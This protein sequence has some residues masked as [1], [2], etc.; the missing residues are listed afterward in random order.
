[1]QSLEIKDLHISIGDKP[2]VN[3][4]SLT[5]NRG[6]VRRLPVRDRKRLRAD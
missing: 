3:G 1:M 2:I 6:E 5:V 4:L